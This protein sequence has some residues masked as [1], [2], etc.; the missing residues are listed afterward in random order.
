MIKSLKDKKILS[1]IVEN[2]RIPISELAKKTKLSREVVQYRLKNLEK[3]LISGY[4][5][6]LNL[7]F[8]YNSIYTLF[9][10]IQGIDKKTTFSLFQKLPSIHWIS[11]TLGKW[12][13]MIT[14]SVN[15]S[16]ELST[17]FDK[18]SS[19]F[20]EYSL[21]YVLVQHM[22]EYKDSYSGLFGENKILVS[23]A[24]K[25]KVEID[26]YDKKILECLTNNA[27]MSNE[28][29][30]N[31]VNLTR[32]SVRLRIK[33]LEKNRIILNYR[34]FIRPQFLDLTS[35]FI[36]IKCKNYNLKNIEKLGLF[37][38]N[39]K[40][41]SYVG[42]TSGDYNII[43]DL[44][45]SSIKELDNLISSIRISFSDI[46]DEIEIFPLIEVNGQNYLPN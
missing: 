18:L 9:L 3:D 34:I 19:L 12:N 16:E 14:F 8:F 27:R 41:F 38:S 30:A 21:K 44:T 6:R 43:G 11:Y 33:N 20:K 28:E 7:N 36:T 23:E 25:I 5:A 17:F 13:Y 31:V 45:E 15:S 1:G 46:I 42:L 4:H 40:S 39:K 26:D 24:E 32:E 2:A 29:I 37:L 35:Y 22:K 10:N